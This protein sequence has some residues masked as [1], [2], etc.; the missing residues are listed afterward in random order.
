VWLDGKIAYEDVSLS[1]VRQ[2]AAYLH[3]NAEG[4]ANAESGAAPA[5]EALHELEIRTV[6]SVFVRVLGVTTEKH[7]AGVVYDAPGINGARVT[8]LLEWNE[9]LLAD[10]LARR[11]PDLVII[12]YGSNEAG[13]A[14]FTTV[15]YHRIFS[16]A[17]QR[18]RRAVPQAS[19]LVIASPDR[20]MR[21]GGQW[22]SLTTLPGIVATQRQ[23]ARE[24]RAAFWDL[25][26]A[27]GGAGAIER[28]N[29]RSSALAQSDRVHLTAAGY[30]LVADALYAELMRNF[31]L[32]RGK[33]KSSDENAK[34]SF[35]NNLS[36]SGFWK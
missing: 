12:A 25:Y 21:T 27:M 1:S 24:N 31:K 9:K 32:Y 16:A 4:E 7:H 35:K 3:I 8:R 19:L 14:N 23:A 17:L 2:E 10:N 13:D 33:L 28:W 29:M 18:I 15:Q 20:Q 34:K 30:R 36:V 5:D 6:K 22:E 26:H 11:H